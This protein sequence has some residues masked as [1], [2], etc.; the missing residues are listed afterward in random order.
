M[1]RETDLRSSLTS[2]FEAG[3]AGVDPLMAVARALA[4]PAVARALASARRLGVFAV[5]KA[6]AAMLEATP[7]T[8]AALAILPTGYPPPRASHA[9]V[10]FASHPS[11]DRSS[12]AAARR[13]LSFFRSFGAEDVILC[14]VSGGASSLLALPR[15]G[16]RLSQKRAAVARLMASGASIVEINRLRK[17]LSAVKG[18]RLGRATP[19]RL[20][21]LVLSDVPGDDPALVGSG[22]TVRARRGDVTLVV[23]SNQLG[24]KAAAREAARGGL[25]PRIA[26]WRLEGEAIEAGRQFARAALRLPAGAVLLAGG[27]TT[28]TL[29]RRPG[30]GGRNLEL[31]LSA[32]LEL[33]GASG[34]ALLAAGSDGIDGSSSAAGALVDGTTIARARRRGLDPETALAR[35]DTERFFTRLSDLFAPGPTGT[36]VGDW[37]FAIRKG[38]GLRTEDL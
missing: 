23:G 27:E 16:V 6:A 35:H 15:E 18:G 30:R 1:G 17:R 25:M 10:L 36:N 13:A 5:G 28:V 32:G 29:S 34:I 2:L 21:T 22:P 31:A 3:L 4:R 7:S 9:E 8:D 33:E 24:L 14:L 38:P 19:A 11:P 26:R 12:V 20:V 37:A